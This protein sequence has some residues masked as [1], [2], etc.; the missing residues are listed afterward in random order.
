VVAGGGGGGDDS[1]MQQDDKTSSSPAKPAQTAVRV[2]EEEVAVGFRP[3]AARAKVQQQQQQEHDG[4]LRL[5]PK[6]LQAL[7]RETTRRSP[8]PALAAKDDT[9][10]E[11]EVEVE[12]EL[13]ESPEAEETNDRSSLSARF[14]ISIEEQLAQSLREKEAMVAEVAAMTR[15]YSKMKYKYGQQAKVQ[16]SVNQALLALETNV[17]DDGGRAFSDVSSISSEQEEQTLGQHHWRH[18]EDGEQ[19]QSITPLPAAIL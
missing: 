9:E 15:K 3:V 1:S 10:K 18:V 11:V 16:A 13:L 6:A 4:T 12:E 8:A 14:G 17:H 2:V 5:G 7:E 19:H